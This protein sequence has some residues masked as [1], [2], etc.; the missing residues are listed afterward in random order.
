MPMIR[1][2]RNVVV[3]AGAGVAA[4]LFGYPLAVMGQHGFDTATW[5]QTVIAPDQWFKFVASLN[6]ADI[7][8][9]YW[10]MARNESDNFAWGGR[11]ALG[12]VA[13]PFA[14]SAVWLIKGREFG[15]KRDPNGVHGAARWASRSEIK[16]MKTGLEL[17][18]DKISGRAVRVSIESNLLTIA[19]PRK[20]KTSGVIIP[21]LA[22][23]EP[24]AWNGP[25]VVIDPKGE[26]FRAVAERRHQ[27]GRTVRC[28][29]PVNLVGGT[30]KWNPLENLDPADILYLQHTAAALLPEALG[31]NEAAAFFRSRANAL[32]VGAMLVVLNS[33]TRNLPE[34]LRL[35]NDDN[36][37]IEGLKK[38]PM[39]PSATDALKIMNA[40][41]KERDP[42]RS[43]AAQAFSWLSDI[44]LRNLVASSSF[45]LAD[46]A[47]GDVDLFV[48]VPTRDT[49]ILAPF[50]R[51][52]LADIFN[53]IRTHH[54][55]QRMVIFIDDAVV[56]GR[57]AAILKASAEL[58]GYGASLW[59]IWQNR[60]QIVG[61][62]GEAGAATLLGTTDMVTVF[63]IPAIDPDE[64]DRWSRAL[65]NFTALIETV[66]D[67]ETETG[68]TSTSTGPEPVRLMTKEELTTALDNDEVIVFPASQFYSRNPV[69]VRKTKAFSDP[70]FAGLITPVAPVGRA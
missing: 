54:S 40:D 2:F 14:L 3:I 17:G 66:S 21:N 51:W 60:S 55:A 28:L 58:P 11:I 67:S 4:I 64:S 69:R 38:L 1:L 52:L 57:F 24:D 19:P 35:L 5:P 48:A 44:R 15:P 23:P 41:P 45:D 7:L 47:N 12:L 49:E 59:T 26:V 31:E 43:T 25:A 53:A 8:G 68:K 33:E 39:E 13:A 10:Q 61:T 30:D 50:L 32:I 6:V 9:T 29:D 20:G 42:I 34:V 62:Y 56:L 37:F 65:G 70:R 63:D 16:Q 36:A 18:L 27:L 46:L 22:C